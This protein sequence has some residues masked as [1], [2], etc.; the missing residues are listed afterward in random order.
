MSFTAIIIE[1]RIHTALEFVLNN[2]CDC[3]SHEW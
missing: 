2:I 3:L 1:P